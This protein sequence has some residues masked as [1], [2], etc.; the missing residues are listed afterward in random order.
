MQREEGYS[1]KY[2]EALRLSIV[3]HRQQMRKGSDVPYIIHPVHVSVILLRHGFSA[4]VAIAG[5]LHD[6][7]E[8]Q[9]YQ[10][11]E[12]ERQFG[13]HVAKMVDALS[14]EKYNTRG[15]KRPW[16]TRKRE[17]VKQIRIASK[18]AV[19]VKAADALHNVESFL[20]DLRREG[21][22][23]W[24]HFNQ[25]PDLQLD[26]YRQIVDISKQRLGSHPLVSE[27][28]RAVQSLAQAIEQTHSS[29]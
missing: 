29:G 7:V 22:Q 21:P 26:Y 11:T 19:A 27:L 16:T 20:S 23:M 15:E 6:M 17:A 9:G 10:L 18:E 13:T 28:A 4:E 14:E 8:D 12:I 25:G 5:L 3:T 24:H 1:A 2:E